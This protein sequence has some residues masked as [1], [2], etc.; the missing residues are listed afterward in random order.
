MKAKSV[1][2]RLKEHLVGGGTMNDG[3]TD[4]LYRE[5]HRI[6]EGDETDLEAVERWAFE[7]ANRGRKALDAAILGLEVKS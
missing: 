6:P 2:A 5:A 4:A 3:E 1:M 7:T